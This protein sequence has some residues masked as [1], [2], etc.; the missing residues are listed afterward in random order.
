MRRRDWWIFAPVLSIL[1]SIHLEK[2]SVGAPCPWTSKYLVQFNI[3]STLPD[4]WSHAGITIDHTS[5]HV[6]YIDNT[7][8]QDS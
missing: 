2:Y 6:T 7:H 8:I 3:F 1:V 5:M 4:H